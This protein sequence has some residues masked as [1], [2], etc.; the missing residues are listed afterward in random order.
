[1]V[2]WT[3]SLPTDFFFLRSIFFRC[4]LSNFSFLILYLYLT[5]VLQTELCSQQSNIEVDDVFLFIQIKDRFLKC[6]CR[7]WIAKK[8]FFSSFSVAGKSE[9]ITSI[10]MSLALKDL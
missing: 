9:K 7:T 4:N 6:V 10:D 5:I 3:I 2:K 8:N 1:M